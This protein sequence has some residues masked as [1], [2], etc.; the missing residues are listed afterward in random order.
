MLYK[1][2]YKLDYG[3][4]KIF[5]SLLFQLPILN[6]IK[7]L[8]FWVRFS[9]TNID[10][11]YNISITNFDRKNSNTGIKFTGKCKLVRNVQIDTCGGII[12]GKNVLISDNVDI[13]T[14]KHEFDKIS[15][16][17]N[18]TTNS[19]LTIGDEVWICKNVI[20]TDSVKTI[21]TGSIIATG[22]VLTKNTGEYEIWGG[23]PAKF[24]R[25]RE[26]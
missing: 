16:F 24:V 25:I 9:T 15:L 26:K 5:S 3:L 22:S 20:I 8:F 7:K 17:Q 12:V 18:K 2:L 11:G 6:M 13:Q 4:Q 19:S 1:F 14:H 23:V 21:G 10:P